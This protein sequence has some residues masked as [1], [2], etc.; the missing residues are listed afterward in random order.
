MSILVHLTASA[1]PRYAADIS[2]VF[3][4]SALIAGATVY[5]A[6][7][8]PPQPPTAGR[9]RPVTSPKPIRVP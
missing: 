6:T 4:T 5:L 2:G 1:T 3:S 8:Q 9:M 7:H